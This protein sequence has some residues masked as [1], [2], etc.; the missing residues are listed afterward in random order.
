MQPISTPSRSGGS[1]GNCKFGD[2][3]REP[4][5][6]AAPRAAGGEYPE[7]ARHRGHPGLRVAA[8]P[9]GPRQ[10]AAQA[11]GRAG[12]AA[13]RRGVASRGRGHRG[14]GGGTADQGGA[15]GR[16]P[17]SPGGQGPACA[18]QGARRPPHSGRAPLPPPPRVHCGTR[19]SP[20]RS[21]EGETE[22]RARGRPG[23]PPRAGGRDCARPASP[24]SRRVPSRREDAAARH[25]GVLGR[26]GREENAEPG[27][28]ARASPGRAGAGPPPWGG[29]ET[30]PA[31]GPGR[32]LPRQTRPRPLA[33][34][35]GLNSA[36]RLTRSLSAEK[37]IRAN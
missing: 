19:T 12:K 32:P 3:A 22:G 37:L 25:E 30:N 10:G 6:A 16:A 24:R 20:W 14:A 34:W 27:S 13:P 15:R 8:A 5:E 18:G 4:S 2:P 28:G 29:R 31:R 7:A 9:R 11:P 1:E 35:K 26:R 33:M 17:R 23:M 36:H 21:G